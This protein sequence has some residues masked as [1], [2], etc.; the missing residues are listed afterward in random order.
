MEP[1]GW[2][3]TLSPGHLLILLQKPAPRPEAIKSPSFRQVPE[4]LLSGGITSDIFLFVY[5][6]FQGGY[7][8][9]VFFLMLKMVIPFI[10]I[11][12]FIVVLK[13][14]SVSWLVL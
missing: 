13:I 4:A 8:I 9:C 7:T 5:K 14:S 12:V 1:R 10:L 6:Y 2:L 11:L 3:A